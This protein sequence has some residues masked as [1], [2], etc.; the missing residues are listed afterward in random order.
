[1]YSNDNTSDRRKQRFG[2][3]VDGR[4][5]VSGRGLEYSVKRGQ[6]DTETNICDDVDATSRG[7]QLILGVAEDST[8]QL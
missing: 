5:D 7:Q 8:Q 4:V 2:S 3:T 6:P 1:M